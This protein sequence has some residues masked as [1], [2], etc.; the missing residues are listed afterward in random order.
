MEDN[1]LTQA[2]DSAEGEDKAGT[3]TVDGIPPATSDDTYPTEDG[4]N[5]T[6]EDPSNENPSNEEPSN[7]EPSNKDSSNEEPSG[8]TQSEQNPDPATADQIY[9]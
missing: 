3:E 4:N 7:E 9:C 6:T 5:G 1:Q 8:G 2:D